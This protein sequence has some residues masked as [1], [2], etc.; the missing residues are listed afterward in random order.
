M[1]CKPP[2]SL[3]EKEARTIAEE[4]KRQGYDTWVG[5]HLTSFS[6]VLGD[7]WCVKIGKRRR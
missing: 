6:D 4:L 1:E 3:T 2:Y 5:L 7:K